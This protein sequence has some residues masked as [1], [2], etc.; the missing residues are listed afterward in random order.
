MRHMRSGSLAAAVFLALSVAPLSAGESA[1]HSQ[2][3]AL[4]GE[5]KL[6]DAE[7][8][9]VKAAQE[10]KDGMLLQGDL[11]AL[12]GDGKGAL[13]RYEEVISGYDRETPTSLQLTALHRRAVVHFQMGNASGASNAADAFLKHQP[14]NLELL[15]IA[16]MTTQFP[17][18]RLE[19][20]DRLVALQPDKVGFHV[21]RSRALIENEK[22]REALDDIELALKLD[23]KSDEALM[24]RGFVHLALGDHA[25][26]VKDHA[27]VARRNPKDPTRSR[28][29]PDGSGQCQDRDG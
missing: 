12:K 16:A 27:T 19:Y 29:S 15:Q 13:A 28:R 14:D 24:M 26:A 6:A 7:P 4:L 21:F 10:S 20:A 25:R 8:F 18:R 9:C 1:A 22:R 5:K 3:A 17:T 23:P 11:L 2:C